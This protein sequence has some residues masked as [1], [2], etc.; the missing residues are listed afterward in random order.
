MRAIIT[1]LVSTLP[2]AGVDEGKVITVTGLSLN[3][4]DVTRCPDGWAE[5]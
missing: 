4:S 1:A 3:G 2:S 5:A